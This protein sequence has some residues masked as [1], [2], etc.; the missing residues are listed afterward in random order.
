MKLI[1]KLR[2]YLCWGCG[3]WQGDEDELETPSDLC[4]SCKNGNG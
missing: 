2:K 1:F 4:P 3:L